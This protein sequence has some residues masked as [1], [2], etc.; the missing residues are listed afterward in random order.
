M[1]DILSLDVQK[2]KSGNTVD[3]LLT[4]RKQRM[5]A[6]SFINNN[7]KPRVITVDKSGSNRR[8]IA[9]AFCGRNGSYSKG[10]VI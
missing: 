6:Q 10:V 7:G 9:L 5:S 8:A 4:K 1:A 2:Y 3:F